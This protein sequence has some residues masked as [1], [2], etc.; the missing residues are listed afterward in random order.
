MTPTDRYLR[1]A[2]LGL[3]GQARKAAEL[4]LRGTIEDRVWRLTLLGLT[5][6]DAT[7]AALRDLGSPHAIARGL[8]RVHTLPRAALTA[9]LLGVQA[10]AQVPTVWALADPTD[11]SCQF[12]EADLQRGRTAAEVRALQG[13]LA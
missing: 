12:D 11:R 8:T 3:H 1:Q 6:A 10:L 9:V 5:E 2:T 4:E 7:Q 13:Q